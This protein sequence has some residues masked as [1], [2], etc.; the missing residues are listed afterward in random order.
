MAHSTLGQIVRFLLGSLSTDCNTQYTG[1]F[2]LQRQDWTQV[3]PPGLDI[4]HIIYWRSSVHG[5]LESA[6]GVVSS[7]RN[8]THR[9]LAIVIFIRSV[10]QRVKLL[11]ILLFTTSQSSP[12][13]LDT[14][15]VSRSG[16][17][18]CEISIPS[19]TS[20]SFH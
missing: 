10:G 3:I 13:V 18:P 4:V 16:D 14:M 11:P 1:V 7:M 12:E 19:D 17:V 5:G 9:V 2:P 15:H 20:Y 8:R 6:L